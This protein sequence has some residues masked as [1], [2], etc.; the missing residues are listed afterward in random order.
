[1]QFKNRISLVYNTTNEHGEFVEGEKKQIRCLVVD[2]IQEQA[3]R[4]D[5]KAKT[6]DLKVIISNKD[7]GAYKDIMSEMKVT[8]EYKG[9]VYDIKVITSINDF[10]GKTKYYEVDMKELRDGT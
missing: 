1:M 4:K 9:K 8:F 2:H 10:N 7:Y 6:Y 3:E 5:T